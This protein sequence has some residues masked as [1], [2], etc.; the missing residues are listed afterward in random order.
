MGW[1]HLFRVQ[2]KVIAVRCDFVA[3]FRTLFD[4]EVS[5]SSDFE[6]NFSGDFEIKSVLGTAKAS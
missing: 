1:V 4:I 5:F 3:F 6:V 2:E